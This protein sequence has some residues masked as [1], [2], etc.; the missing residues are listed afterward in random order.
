MADPA[1]LS[2]LYLPVAVGLGA[3]HAL[4]PGHAK[5]LTAAYLVGIRGTWRDA[6]VLGL[7]AACTHAGVVVALSA[8]AIWLGRTAFAGE[9]LR[10]LE[11]ASGA[12]V[13]AIG[14]W[15]LS[16]RWLRHRHHARACEHGHDHDHDDDDDH[17]HTP[18][19]I[20]S[21]GRPSNWQ[22]ILFGASG[23]LLPCPASVSVMLLALSVGEAAIG[24]V[25]AFAFGVGLALALVAVGLAAVWGAGLLGRR[26]DVVGRWAPLVSALMVTLSGV[27]ALAVGLRH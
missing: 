2:L 17:H 20:P 19:P 15:L 4:E 13:I 21:E 11:I 14:L 5:A 6:V 1:S 3:L 12:I 7:S 26:F 25:V 9:A 24:L 22:I 18:P 27:F 8:L 23:G 10:W 16:R